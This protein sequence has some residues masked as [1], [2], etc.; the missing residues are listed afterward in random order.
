M[1]C[2][3]FTFTIV[4]TSMF[5]DVMVRYEATWYFVEGTLEVNIHLQTKRFVQFVTIS[6]K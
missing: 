4:L 1:K 6:L 3:K 2:R 5:K